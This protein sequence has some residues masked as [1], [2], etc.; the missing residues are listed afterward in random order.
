M[1]DE[2]ILHNF[3]QWEK[4]L[5][6][7]ES[8]PFD[9]DS[10][11]ELV[12]H[13]EKLIH[14]HTSLLKSRTEL[15]QLIYRDMDTLLTKFPYL[16]V[17]WIKYADMVFTIDGL[18]PSI[19]IYTR[20]LL[21]FP[22]SLDLWNKYTDVVLEYKLK[23]GEELNDIFEEGCTKIGYHF[24]SHS[25]WDKYL[26]WADTEYGKN[27]IDYMKILLKVVRIPLHQYAR[28]TEEFNK[29]KLNFS[30]S[31]LIAVDDLRELV[32][33]R[34]PSLEKSQVEEYIESNSKDIINDY[35]GSFLKNVQKRSEDKW[36]F[37]SE[38][39]QDFSFRVMTKEEICLWIS[40]LDYEE[41][42]HRVNDG[43]ERNV[44]VISLYERALIPS[45][46]NSEIWVKYLRFLIQNKGTEEAIMLNF[47]KSC[48]HFVSLDQTDLR[49]MY[50]RYMELKLGNIE[51]CKNMF[52]KMTENLPTDTFVISKYIEF[53]LK[54][55]TEDKRTQ[56]ID[57]LVTTVR[58]HPL[59]NV[60]NKLKKSKISTTM[61][62][63]VQNEDLQKLSSRLNF[64]TTGQLLINAVTYIWLVNNDVKKSRDILVS[65][66]R[67]EVVRSC[68]PYWYF[69]FKFELV[70]RNKNNITHVIEALKTQSTLSVF[71]VNF[72]I[73]E[74]NDFILKNIT[75]DEI[76]QMKKEIVKNF[77]ETDFESSMHMKHFLKARLLGTNRNDEEIIHKRLYRENGHPAASS[78]GRPT[79][80]NPIPINQNTYENVE[81]Y[82]LPRFRNV[83]KANSA[84]R[85][86]HEID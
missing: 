81:A 77:L 78:E 28:Y 32:N 26:S 35:F 5:K 34:M 9:E 66:L 48:D 19:D 25:F 51:A 63:E 52:L 12:S 44:E 40:Y 86:I 39:V 60:F 84:I 61:T 21:V 68:K 70:H 69:F 45:C 54:Y 30:A 67:S 57:D 85:Y 24:Q 72:L 8:D 33:K 73:N 75:L 49:F 11:C 1:S 76:E 46:L 7:I 4:Y 37:E 23:K 18:L 22:N 31:D 16:Y 58:T 41:N 6:D 56:F 65:F 59:N 42:F 36:K 71:D 83:E 10:W 62:L 20:A 64:W 47:Q 2:S 3:P 79:L 14:N 50:I 17:Y 27:S 55:T 82:P 15:K 80:T 38:V 29:L 43:L 13:H 53:L 74:Y